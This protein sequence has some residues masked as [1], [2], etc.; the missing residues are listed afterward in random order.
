VAV[1]GER[2]NNLL[3][4]LNEL[5]PLY[6]ARSTSSR[7]PALLFCRIFTLSTKMAISSN[8]SLFQVSILCILMSCQIFSR[9]EAWSPLRRVYSRVRQRVLPTTSPSSSKLIR[10]LSFAEEQRLPRQPQQMASSNENDLETVGLPEMTTSSSSDE[11]DLETVDLDLLQEENELLRDAIRTLEEENYR[12]KQRAG[13][14]ILENFEGEGRFSN[15]T[16]FEGEFDSLTMMGP[17][18]ESGEAAMWC[19]ELEEGER[20]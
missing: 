18:I 4:C 1:N 13:K 19:D 2:R 10:P 17:E 9:T 15:S 3:I 12:L 6:I 5:A 14:I 11:N 7:Q 20:L 16:W 8:I